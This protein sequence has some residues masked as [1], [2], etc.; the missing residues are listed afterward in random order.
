MHNKFVLFTA[1]VCSI[2]F[3]NCNKTT[4]T[5]PTSLRVI[6]VYP[7]SQPQDMYLDDALMQPAA[8]AYGSKNNYYSIQ[9]GTYTFK[10]AQTGTTSFTIN[11]NID[12]S[13]G[14]NYL[15]FF[16]H[17]GDTLQPEAA[18]VAPTYLGFDTSEIRFF[19]FS[20]NSPVLDIAFQL[21]S[22]AD[23]LITYYDTTYTVYIGRYFNDQ[24][25]NSTYKT[26]YALP[27]GNYNLK[28]RYTDTTLAIDS[29]DMTLVNGKAYTIYTR[30]YTDSTS[31]VP[32]LIIDTIM[33]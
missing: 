24:Y 25:D 22:Y 3:I 29:M 31:N 1:L 17:V 7:G 33:H 10:V 6:N 16:A 15:M 2:A 14:K 21:K 28:L 32:P 18:E 11:D 4:L 8:I 20:P 19:N 9:P 12:F 26:F 5:T 30:G 27:S 23:T 13:T